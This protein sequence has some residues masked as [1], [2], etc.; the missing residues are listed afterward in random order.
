M[1]VVYDGTPVADKA[2]ATAATLVRDDDGHLVIFALADDPDEASCL[3]QQARRQWAG[4]G[5]ELSFQTLGEVSVSRLA[6]LVAHEER[7]KLVLPTGAGALDDEAVLDLLE[8]VA[9][10]LCSSEGGLDGY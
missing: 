6:Y 10:R 9:R 2:V 3:E 1:R 5:L 7:G 8:L 4:T